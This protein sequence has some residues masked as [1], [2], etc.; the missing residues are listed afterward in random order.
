MRRDKTI[1]DATNAAHARPT[2][3]AS[4]MNESIVV[5]RVSRGDI[6]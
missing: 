1:A 6:E 3:T 4:I 2:T 5:P